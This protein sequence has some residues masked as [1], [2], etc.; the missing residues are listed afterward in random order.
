MLEFLSQKP[1]QSLKLIMSNQVTFIYI[2]LL[3]IQKI[4]ERF[5]KQK[6]I[7]SI[8]QKDNMN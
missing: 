3:T 6:N 2:A 8:M 4:K 5:S 7:L 1:V